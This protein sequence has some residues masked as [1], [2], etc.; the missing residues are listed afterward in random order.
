MA[1]ARVA[2][3]VSHEAKGQ[4]SAEEILDSFRSSWT[5]KAKTS[6]RPRSRSR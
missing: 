5:Q 3:R 6:E 2:A 1:A 4:R